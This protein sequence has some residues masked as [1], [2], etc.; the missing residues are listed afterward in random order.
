MNSRLLFSSWH[1]SFFID[2][3]ANTVEGKKVSAPSGYPSFEVSLSMSEI[4]L[5]KLIM[6]FILPCGV[7]KEL[8]DPS[9]WLARSSRDFLHLPSGYAK[10]WG[11]KNYW[12]I[13]MLSANFWLYSNSEGYLKSFEYRF[14]VTQFSIPSPL[15]FYFSSSSLKI[16]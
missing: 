7:L 12:W 13:K 3:I 10:W 11:F 16:S 8:I 1:Y 9:C 5:Q 14:L 4:I 15:I 6:Q 2:K